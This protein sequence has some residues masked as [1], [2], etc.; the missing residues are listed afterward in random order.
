M[1]LNSNSSLCSSQSPSDF[2]K[3]SSEVITTQ[4]NKLPPAIIA[5][6]LQRDVEERGGAA[7]ALIDTEGL[8]A[9]WNILRIKFHKLPY[10]PTPHSLAL[11]MSNPAVQFSRF[12]SI[13]KTLFLKLSS[14]DYSVSS[15]TRLL[16]VEKK[17]SSLDFDEF[18]DSNSLCNKILLWCIS[19]GY[20]GSMKVT[21]LKKGYGGEVVNVLEFVT[22]LIESKVRLGFGGER[23][24]S[25]Y[26]N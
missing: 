6:D 23:S 2:K 3:K 10:P 19:Q 7:L 9:R 18:S 8:V 11:K 13:F 26:F 4:M 15:P 14:V 22:S 12:R 24:V 25:E 16:S 20:D 17:G 21:D 1:I 5:F